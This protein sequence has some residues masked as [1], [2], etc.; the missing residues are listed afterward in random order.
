MSDLAR[1]QLELDDA[2]H[3]SQLWYPRVRQPSEIVFDS[4]RNVLRR[5]DERQNSE[6]N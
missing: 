1:S 3:M 6:A 2:M 5:R 4:G